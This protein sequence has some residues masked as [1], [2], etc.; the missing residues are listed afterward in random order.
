MI[1]GYSYPPAYILGGLIWSVRENLDI[2]LGI[3]GGFTKP[4]ADVAIH[5]G[6][7]WRF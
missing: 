5:G 7:T 1:R 4:A 3:K 6:I 2:G